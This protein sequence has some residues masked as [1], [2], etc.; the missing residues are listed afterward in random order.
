MRGVAIPD[1][2][3]RGRGE[4]R[5]QCA[6]GKGAQ[7][8]AGQGP[9]HALRDGHPFSRGM[10]PRSASCCDCPA[11]EQSCSLAPT[12]P[13][14]SA[15]PNPP[16]SQ[17]PPRPRSSALSLSLCEPRTP[18]LTHRPQPATFLCRSNQSVGARRVTRVSSLMVELSQ[19]PVGEPHR[20][21]THLLH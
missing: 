7:Q 9:Q 18:T 10:G 11:V 3:R 17:P 12:C 8:R 1:L 21:A 13:S 16:R 6:K 15:W 2:L 5:L 14:R 20:Y 4:E 19:N